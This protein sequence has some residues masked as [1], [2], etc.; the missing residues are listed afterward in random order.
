MNKSN[1]TGGKN[2]KKY[3][4]VRQVV[5]EVQTELITRQAG[6]TYGIVKSICGGSRILVLCSDNLERSAII[7]GKFFKKKKFWFHQNEVVLCELNNGGDDKQCYIVHKYTPKDA[8]KLKKLKHITFEEINEYE[9]VAAGAQTIKMKNNK[10]YDDM[11]PSSGSESISGSSDNNYETY[12]PNKDI[13]II[14]EGDNG[15]SESIDLKKL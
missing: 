9:M 2:H 4:K 1:Q 7:P 11:M 10:N 5:E 13:V 12:N 6:Q 8:V 15:S 3:K 14:E